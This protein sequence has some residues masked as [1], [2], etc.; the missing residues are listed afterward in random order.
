M[1]GGACPWGSDVA[2]STDLAEHLEPTK[3]LNTQKPPSFLG[4]SMAGSFINPQNPPN[5]LKIPLVEKFQ[6]IQQ[7]IQPRN[8]ELNPSVGIN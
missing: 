5:R 8:R 2:G 1:V 3:M 6:L 4:E 7:F